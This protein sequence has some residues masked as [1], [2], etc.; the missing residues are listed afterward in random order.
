MDV[1][2]G[3]A[4]LV[5][6][7]VGVTVGVGVLLG[8]V[9]GVYVGADA[10]GR[11]ETVCDCPSTATTNEHAE[12][13]NASAQLRSARHQVI[14]FIASPIIVACRG[15]THPHFHADGVIRDEIR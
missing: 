6:V 2:L 4:V 13:S 3:V 9:V 1:A 5:A 14:V 8:A 7:G 11:M 15:T 12:S 10:S